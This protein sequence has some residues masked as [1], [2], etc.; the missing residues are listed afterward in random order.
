[1][2]YMLDGKIIPIEDA[3]TLSSNMDAVESIEIKAMLMAYVDS[4][5]DNAQEKVVERQE[6]RIEKELL[7][8]PNSEAG[9]KLAWN[10]KKN[11]DGTIT[12]NSLKQESEVVL[13]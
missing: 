12:L 6:K 3:M 9:L 4:F 13:F 11:P 10:F 1:M 5:G 2:K 7:T 8:D